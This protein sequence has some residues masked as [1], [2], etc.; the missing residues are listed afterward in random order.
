LE[1]NWHPRTPIPGKGIVFMQFMAD[2]LVYRLLTP[3]MT[4]EPW[5]EDGD[6]NPV[7]PVAVL[8]RAPGQLGDMLLLVPNDRKSEA[9]SQPITICQQVEEAVLSPVL[10]SVA[11]TSQRML[12]VRPI[13]PISLDAYH[14]ALE[15]KRRYDALMAAKQVATALQIYSVDNDDLFPTGDPASAL[16]PYLRNRD[17]MKG[18]VFTLPNA[19][20]MTEIEDPSSTEIGY[21]PLPGGRVV[22][23]ADSHVKWVPDK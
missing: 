5:S 22:A 14:R 12:W 17:I 9:G 15:A 4:F 13:Q 23:Y 10:N 21:I 16:E 1:Q 11:Y 2:N 18:F 8:T 6:P 19:K 3:K 7:P 20:S